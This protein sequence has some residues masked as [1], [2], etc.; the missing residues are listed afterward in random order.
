MKKKNSKKIKKVWLAGHRGL[1]GRS[2]LNTLKKNNFNVLFKTS[3]ELDLRN[4]TKVKNFL[5]K[6]KPDLVIISAGKVGGILANKKQPIDFYYDNLTIGNNIIKASYEEKIKHLIYLGSSCIYPKNIKRKI[7]ESDL[8]KGELE[9]TNEA[10]AIAK[11]SCTKYCNFI[12][13]NSKFNYITVMP[14]NVYGPN[15]NFHS[16]NSHVMAS[17]I[18]KFVY[19]KNKREKQ[20]IVW[21]S[22]LPKREFIYVEDLSNAILQIIRKNYS[23][24]IINV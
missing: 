1:V 6:Y 18:K 19:A 3:K 12:N 7:N 9:K 22:G 24:D 13:Q 11:I 2:I 5:K 16:T 10:Y 14:C 4:F 8:L 23:G 20:V 15:D 21:G 17:L